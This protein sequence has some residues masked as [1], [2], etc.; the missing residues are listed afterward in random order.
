MPAGWY[1]RAHPSQPEVPLTY[2]RVTL[3]AAALAALGALCPPLANG[4]VAPPDTSGPFAGATGGFIALSVPDVEASAR[5]YSEKLG[6]RLVMRIPR[7][8]KIVGGAALE[9][10]GIL[11]ELIQREDAKPGT[12]LAELTHG[13]VKAGI[14]VADFERAVAGLRARGVVFFAGPYPARPG[15]RANVMFKDNAGNMLQVLGPITQ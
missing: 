6:L 9:G 13:I 15:Q 14:L 11:L 12:A 5:W 10:G 8:D 7:M 2:A 1:R 3:V 4:Q